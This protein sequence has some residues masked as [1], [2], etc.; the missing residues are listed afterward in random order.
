MAHASP[1]I[2]SIMMNDRC[3]GVTTRKPDTNRDVFVE[4]IQSKAS[5]SGILVEDPDSVTFLTDIC[6]PLFVQSL[7][8]KRYFITMKTNQHRYTHVQ[9]LKIRGEGPQSCYDHI[10]CIDKNTKKALRKCTATTRR[11]CWVLGKF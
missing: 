5:A 1:D 9:T 4:T 8:G 2:L 7:G 3:Y 10:P 11:S 6:G